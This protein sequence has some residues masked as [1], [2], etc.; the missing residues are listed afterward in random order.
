MYKRGQF[1]PKDDDNPL[2]DP[3]FPQI[4]RGRAKVA[5]RVWQGMP[6]VWSEAKPSKQ[7][8][9]SLGEKLAMQILAQKTGEP[10]EQVDTSRNNAPID[11]WG[12]GMAVEVKTGL[13]TNAY[14]SMHW[15][16]TIGQPGKE[17]MA[18]VEKLS[19]EEYK[20]HQDWKYKQILHR[21]HSLLADLNK[22]VPGRKL[23]GMTVGII[24]HPSLEKADVYLMEGY[25]LIIPPG[26]H[27]RYYGEHTFCILQI[28]R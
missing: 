16:A 8:V 28:L 5:D 18:A 22:A 14:K 13:A 2:D 27:S 25:H 9:G 24:M 3:T 15:R 21:K 23:K 17:E 12:D 19:K 1:A 7:A 20:K 11:I 26:L 6:M 10:F 4:A